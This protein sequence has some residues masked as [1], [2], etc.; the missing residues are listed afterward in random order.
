M[1]DG[2]CSVAT[3]T[4]KLKLAGGYSSTP[5]PTA[6]AVATALAKKLSSRMTGFYYKNLATAN[7]A[8][9]DCTEKIGAP[10]SSCAP[11]QVTCSCTNGMFCNVPS[12]TDGES[13]TNPSYDAGCSTVQKF[14][15]PFKDVE[16]TKVGEI[17]EVKGKTKAMSGMNGGGINSMMSDFVKGSSSLLAAPTLWVCP[18]K[19]CINGV[20]F[21]LQDTS[22]D[23]NGCTAAE[24]TAAASGT[25]CGPL[26][27]P[28]KYV[29]PGSSVGGNCS[30]NCS[31]WA[32]L[33]KS[34]VNASNA[35]NATLNVSGRPVSCTEAMNMNLIIGIAVAAAVVILAVVALV[36][37][38][39]GCKKP[40]TETAKQV[41]K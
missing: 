13:V 24:K 5:A 26:P 19:S 16:V 37:F 38:K 23:I 41:Q 4:F 20:S 34:F 32:E 21:T 31:C 11:A 29:A 8:F 1:A 10:S 9:P 6:G 33:E 18:E 7:S 35:S 12:C 22:A 39:P 15:C 2:I 17:Y 25:G 14:N 27:T 40:P 30:A 3:P 28:S 36:Y